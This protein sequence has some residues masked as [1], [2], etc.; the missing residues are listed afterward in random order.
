M[1]L[2]LRRR[3]VVQ[4]CPTLCD[5]MDCSTPGL[6]VHHQLPKLAQT[7]G[8]WVGDAIQPSHPLSSPSPPAFSLSQNQGLLEWV[9]S[10]HQVAKVLGLHSASASVLSMNIQ[11]WFFFKMDWLDLL[12]VQGTLESLLQQHSWKASVLW[13]SVFFLVQLSHRYMTTGKTITLTIRTIVGKV[14]SV[15]FNTLSR[16]VTAFLPRS[17]RLLI[18]CLLSPFAVI[19]RRKSVIVFIASPSISPWSDG[20]GCHDLSFLNVEFKTSFFTLLFH[21]LQEAL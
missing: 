21:P 1:N 8:H 9:S 10:S 5:P 4:S 15:L 7:H 20:T 19:W 13:R 17:K 14:M 6:P 11:G 16:F 3:S 2:T 18:S 12:A